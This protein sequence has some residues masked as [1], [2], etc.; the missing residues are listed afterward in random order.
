MLDS[1]HIERV[2]FCGL[3]MGGTIGQWL[4]IHAPA[5]L[6]K[7]ILAN[8][9][10]KIGNAETWDARIATVMQEG[11]APVIP[12]TLE[13]WFTAG[14]RAE[15]PETVAFIR[16]MLE[17]TDAQGYAACCAAIRDADFR[18]ELAQIVTPTLI[19]AGSD[20]PVTT[21]KDAQFLASNIRG[22][23]CVELKAAH[24]SNLGAPF[25]FNTALSNFLRD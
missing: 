14:F 8:S 7:L 20:D 10:A 3:S 22:A 4:G 5:R 17:G 25:E 1:L 15:Q 6:E 23:H 12:G 11:L 18:T 16:S 21:P 24:L 2:S 9:A 19:I 13:R